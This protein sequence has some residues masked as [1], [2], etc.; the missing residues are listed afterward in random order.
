MKRNTIFLT[1]VWAL[2]TWA[3]AQQPTIP[4]EPL[5]IAVSNKTRAKNRVNSRRIASFLSP[6]APATSWASFQTPWSRPIKF[7]CIAPTELAGCC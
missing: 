1:A 3:L 6:Y 4:E 5:S 2:A 7:G